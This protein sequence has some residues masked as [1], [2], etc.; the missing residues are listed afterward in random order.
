M[1]IDNFDER[2][3]QTS[4]EVERFYRAIASREEYV[5]ETWAD[6]LPRFE[7]MENRTSR[8]RMLMAREYGAR[9]CQLCNANCSVQM[10]TSAKN[11]NQ[12]RWYV[13]CSAGYGG[14]HT[15]EFVSEVDI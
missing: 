14:G 12:G 8:M 2:Q 6:A 3:I 10:T 7:Q 5:P 4:D 15:F 1:Q 9:K 11:G 13:K